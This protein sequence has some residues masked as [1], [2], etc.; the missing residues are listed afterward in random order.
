MLKDVTVQHN[1]FY[2]PYD[3]ENLNGLGGDHAIYFRGAQNI[4][5][6]GITY[7]DYK[8][9]QLADLSLNQAVILRL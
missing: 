5:V 8:M 7:V 9:V 3:N 6:V 1:F 4:T 2:S